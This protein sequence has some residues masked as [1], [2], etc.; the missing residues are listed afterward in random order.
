MILV[1][2]G[3][4]G[5]RAVR[6][7]DQCRSADDST[8]DAMD[9]DQWVVRLSWSA[10]VANQRK[11]SPEQRTEPNQLWC[12][13]DDPSAFDWMLDQ[14]HASSNE[15]WL[16]SSVHAGACQ[17]L[18][19]SLLN[20]GAT[21]QFRIVSWRDLPRK[22]RVDFPEKVGTDRLLASHAAWLE[23]PKRLTA[24][25]SSVIVVQA[26]TAVTI[27]CVDASGVFQGGAIMPGLGLSLQLLAAGTDKLPWVAN[28]MV[29]ELPVLPGRNTSEAISAG[30]HAALV[31]GVGYA[32]HRYRDQ[33]GA[34]TPVVISGG[35]GAILR[36]LQQGN[37]HWIDQ[38]VLRG[39]HWIAAK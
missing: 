23:L 10:S 2:I 14:L 32:I 36:E 39:L 12:S 31:G 37:V 18:K 29:S 16:V 8:S 22:P 7:S 34:S 17:L 24:E 13:V 5:L 3:N 26:G 28:H 15:S 27:D 38:L 35:D 4:S 11:E 1:D 20:R 33:L 9:F 21:S 30:V 19:Q 25:P 6:A